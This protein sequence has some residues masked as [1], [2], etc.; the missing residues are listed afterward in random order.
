MP[1]IPHTEEDIRD[2][3]A[4]IGVKTIETLFDEIPANLKTDRFE[5]IPAGMSELEVSRLI[6]EKTKAIQH[7][8]CFVGAGAYEHHI[9][10]AIW[11]IASRGEYL[12]AYTPYQSEASQGTLQLLYE[13]QTMIANLT[14]MEVANASL[15]D[16]ASS[17]A[18]A[19]LMATRLNRKAK[20][21]RIL[22]AGS[23]HPH[24]LQTVQSI[25]NYAGV[26]L[27]TLPFDP[28]Q[29]KLSLD[30]LV[31]YEG[32]A[33][34]ALVIQ[35]PNFFGCYEEVDQLTDWAHR[36]GAFVIACVNPISLGV[37]KEPG[38]WGKDGADIVC[39]EGQ[40][41][42]IPLAGGGPYFGFFACR[43][44]H[45]RE[46]PG[47][48]VGGTLDRDHNRGYTLTLQAREQH[49]RRAKATSNICTNQGLLT[50][51]A[52]I[53]MALLGPQGLQQVAGCCWDN[54]HELV[55]KLTQLKGI[56]LRFEQD[57]FHEAVLQVPKPATQVLEALMRQGI[58]GGYNLSPHYPELGE[59]LLI[60]AT[61][62]KTQADLQA[63]Y[64]ALKQIL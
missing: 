42:G 41:L 3:L 18:E 34:T 58:Q 24:Y 63:Y 43:A 9:P 28:K 6:Q 62:T 44:A 57:F 33:L 7:G 53:Y 36:Q 64:N 32:Q 50:T 48:I 46:M 21:H 61:E 51:A 26:E 52:T 54:T 55:T 37:L 11:Q 12:T 59:C 31:S 22:L 1:F 40:P 27:I 10:A 56:Q 15:Y 38:A 23:T 25:L 5:Q 19:V 8:L 39:G 47:R 17:L 30:N 2:M 20:T 29:G 14:G 45:I 60:C 49:I 13:F 35:Q 4:R 16:G